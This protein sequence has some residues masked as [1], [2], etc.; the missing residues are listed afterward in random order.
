MHLSAL[1]SGLSGP[2]LQAL[3]AVRPT[4]RVSQERPPSGSGI[5]Q[6]IGPEKVT[7]DQQI[8]MALQLN[9]RASWREIGQLLGTSESTVAR[10][11]RALMDAGVIRSTAVV[12]PL[13]CGFG[14]PVLVQISCSA[15]RA[16]AAAARLA[17]RDDVRFLAAVTG[18]FDIVAEVVVASS[19]DLAR[20]LLEELAATPGVLRT[21][22]ETVLRTFKLAHDWSR[23]LLESV[24]ALPARPPVD[25]RSRVVP[26]TLDSLDLRLVDVLRDNGRLTF[27]D[28]AQALGISESAAR[29]RVDHL[30]GSGC[31]TP[32][33][34]VDPPFLGYG[35]EV[36][37][38]IRVELGRLEDVAS[39]LVDR[40]EVRYLSA[41]SGYSDL[42]AEVILPGQE[43]LYRFR[44][45]V[46][47]R[48]RGIHDLDMA[49]ELKN[50]VR[51]YLQVPTG[52]PL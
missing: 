40:P 3:A 42:V 14:Y 32:V 48:L 2:C 47:G 11:A 31:V 13:R 17:E 19:R 26:V 8:A 20:V 9:G 36:L 15:D 41:T 24:V 30:L 12:D 39:A 51:S 18:A 45:E 23:P 52:R 49:L 22:T 5:R 6:R 28:I 50:F 7:I 34:L 37:V 44:T 43:D 1:P 29:R 21:T 46:L 16:S 10:R 35:V 33:T 25:V 4:N 38:F 27:Q